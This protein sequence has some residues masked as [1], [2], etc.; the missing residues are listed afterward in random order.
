MSKRETPMVL[1]YWDELEGQLI[2]EF[3][4]T[5]KSEGSGIKLL[6]GL[7][8]LNKKKERLPVSSRPSIEGEDVVV[9]QAKNSRLGMYLMGQTLFSRELVLKFKPKSVLSVALCSKNDEVLG[10]MLEKHEGC[11]VVVCP[12][13]VS[14]IVS[15]TKK[16]N[17]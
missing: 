14:D 13:E 4:A 15:R 10:P 2:E 8:I 6:D 11:K 1:W 17:M 3:M 16:M 12:K 7:V 9:I 5:K